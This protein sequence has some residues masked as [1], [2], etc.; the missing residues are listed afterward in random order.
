M[1]KPALT[2]GPGDDPWRPPYPFLRRRDLRW[3]FL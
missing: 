2:G 3:L 1:H